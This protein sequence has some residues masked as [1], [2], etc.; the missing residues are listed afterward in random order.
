MPEPYEEEM[1]RRGRKLA[2]TRGIVHSDEVLFGNSL[3]CVSIP[4]NDTSDTLISAIL[5]DGTW[6]FIYDRNAD[7]YR[8]EH[9]Q[10]VVERMREVMVLHDLAEI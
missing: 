3:F 5:P 9:Y 2:N 7:H 8:P 10:A 1:I 4:A 6:A